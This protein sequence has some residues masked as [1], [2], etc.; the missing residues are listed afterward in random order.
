MSREPVD[1]LEAARRWR[2]E[3]RGVAVATVVNT[4]GSSP[5]PA[6]SQLVVDGDGAFVGSVS[7]GC[8]EGEVV[9]EALE[10]IAGGEP[11]MLEFGVTN[12]RA[13]EVGLACGGRVQVYV[14]RLE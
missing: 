8:I 12:E 10:V 5:R 14:E 1:V 6:G 2:D 7:G 11:R 9:R 13:W 4:W 3:G